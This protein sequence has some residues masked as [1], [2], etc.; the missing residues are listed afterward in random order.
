M[1][2][3]SEPVSAFYWYWVTKKNIRVCG[4]TS[5]G[6][7]GWSKSILP[8]YIIDSFCTMR[9]PN[10]LNFPKGDWTWRVGL[11]WRVASLVNRIYGKGKICSLGSEFLPFWE[12]P[13]F[14]EV[15]VQSHKICRVLKKWRKIDKYWYTRITCPWYFQYQNKQY[16]FR[17][18][19]ADRVWIPQQPEFLRLRIT[20]IH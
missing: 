8:G 12:Y 16:W 13:L 11:T 10:H 15:A 19:I 3:R 20:K 9:M 1:T 5:Y 4:C 6:C 14:E 17:F 18:L 7:A 2:L